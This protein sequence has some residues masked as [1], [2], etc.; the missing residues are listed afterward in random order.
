VRTPFADKAPVRRGRK[1]VYPS[2][3]RAT[4]R[5]AFQDVRQS[6]SNFRPVPVDRGARTTSPSAIERRGNFK[7]PIGTKNFAFMDNGERYRR[8][9]AAQSFCRQAIEVGLIDCNVGD[10]PEAE[11]I[12]RDTI[13]ANAGFASGSAWAWPWPEEHSPLTSQRLDC[14]GVFGRRQ[15]RECRCLLRP[16]RPAVSARCIPVSTTPDGEHKKMTP[17]LGEV[18]QLYR[19]GNLR[20]RRSDKRR[21]PAP[22]WSADSASADT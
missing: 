12:A 18:I 6:I 20:G 8:C 4:G 19:C 3:H 10:S 14:E 5:P 1:V 7:T 17:P 9:G 21:Q 16:A 15:T 11:T 13:H 2:Q 22:R